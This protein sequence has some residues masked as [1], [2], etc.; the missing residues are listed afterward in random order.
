MVGHES[1]EGFGP[2]GPV[3]PLKLSLPATEFTWIVDAPFDAAV[4]AAK[5]GA[6]WAWEQL[7]SWLSPRLLG[8]L[9]ARGSRDPEDALGE[10]WLQLARNVATFEGDATGFRSWAFTVAHHR[11]IDEARR[12]KRSPLTKSLDDAL[13]EDLRRM[14]VVDAESDALATVELDELVGSIA[15]LSDLQQS[16]LLLRI[17]GDLSVAQT[18]E[19]LGTSESAI[20]TAQ[21]RAISK[22]RDRLENPATKPV[23]PSVTEMT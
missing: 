5:E 18:A 16:T 19:A 6:P 23:S 15:F 12:R 4:L 14:G 20:K 13:A 2:R 1:D 7:Y 22:L 11:V 17:I 9:R 10:T 3:R 21:Y 8:Y